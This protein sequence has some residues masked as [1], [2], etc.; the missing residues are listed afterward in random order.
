MSSLKKYFSKLYKIIIQR[1][2]RILPGHLAFFIVLSIMPI[3]TL[4]TFICTFF[5]ISMQDIIGNLE[6]FIPNDVTKIIEPFLYNTNSANLSFIMMLIGFFI[7]SNGSHSIIIVSN[8]LYDIKDRGYISRRIKAFLIL[9]LLII[10]FIFILVFI[11]FGNIILKY[12]FSFNLIPDISSIF[13]QIFVY[14]KYPVAFILVYLFVKALYTMAPDT[15]MSSRYVTKGAFFTTVGWIFVTTIY[16][17]YANKIANYDLWYG[18]LSN[19]IILMIWI[20][21]ISYIFVIG[22]AVNVNE[23]NYLVN[24]Q[25]KQ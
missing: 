5:S 14:F 19:I 23:Y 1:D 20:Y 22:I 25:I 24:K 3:I 17:F 15:K 13:Y 10:L 18:S 4:V 11:G 6:Q 2:M 8:T 9:I 7:A 21:I 16:S 12:I